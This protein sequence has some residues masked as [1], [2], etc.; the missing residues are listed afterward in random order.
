MENAYE[1]FGEFAFANLLWFKQQ[2]VSFDL[3]NMMNEPDEVL[4]DQ[5]DAS[6]TPAQSKDVSNTPLTTLDTLSTAAKI[7]LV[8]LCL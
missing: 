4:G 8:S 3:L 2:G 6:Y 7:L 1:E 5:E